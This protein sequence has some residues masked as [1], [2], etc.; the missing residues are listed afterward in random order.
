M[1]TSWL[2][3]ISLIFW[4]FIGKVVVFSTGVGN[5]LDFTTVFT[6]WQNFYSKW[7]SPLW[8]HPP[9]V[10]IVLKVLYSYILKT[11]CVWWLADVQWSHCISWCFCPDNWIVQTL[12]RRLFSN[13][14]TGFISTAPDQ[15]SCRDFT[16]LEVAA[17]Q[18][19]F[20]VINYWQIFMYS[21]RFWQAKPP[22]CW[23]WPISAW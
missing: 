22:L 9:L 3:C 6:L 23:K 20:H 2:Y 18:Y 21:K 10:L 13:N 1:K 14:L 7:F 4:Q 8:L 5:S 12:P 17:L 15:Y 19:I 16:V 11:I